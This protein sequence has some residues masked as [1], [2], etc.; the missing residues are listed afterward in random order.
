MHILASPYI[1]ILGV[2]A[3]A[4]GTACGSDDT[5]PVQ[6]PPVVAKTTT[7]SGDLQTGL[8]GTA[9]PNT[10]RVVVTRDGE[11]ASGIPV[12]WSTASGSLDPTSA[13]TDAEGVST[14]TWTLGDTPG[15]VSATAGV[16]NATDS[17]VTFTATAI[18]GGGED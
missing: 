18:V 16:T 12:A 6:S 14:S 3:M 10:L 9:L 1:R 13:E 2:M 11:P 8:V 15:A 4:L 5:G 17:P 7:K